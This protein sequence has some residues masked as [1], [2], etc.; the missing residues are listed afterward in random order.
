[1]ITPK[2]FVAYLMAVRTSAMKAELKT[3]IRVSFQLSVWPQG[4]LA[5]MV[6]VQFSLQSY[7]PSPFLGL[8]L[9][10][11]PSALRLEYSDIHQVSQIHCALR[12][13]V[14]SL[15]L[16]QTVPGLGVHRRN[17]RA[18]WKAVWRPALGTQLRTNSRARLWLP[19]LLSRGC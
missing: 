11:S 9:A 8:H 19:V 10:R 3:S 15:L 7:S 16:P 17:G 2:L 18:D 6:R 14:Q 1:M 4:L 12:L 13:R 5:A